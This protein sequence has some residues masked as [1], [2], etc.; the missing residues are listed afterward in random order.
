V[1]KPN[2][3]FLVVSY[4]VP[5][6]R[7]QYLQEETYKWRV[8]IHTVR[9]S[10]SLFPIDLI[11][12]Y[13][14]T[15]FSFFPYPITH[16][17]NRQ[18]SLPSPPSPPPPRTPRTPTPCTTSMSARRASMPLRL[19]LRPMG[20]RRALVRLGSM[21]GMGGRSPGRRWGARRRGRGRSWCVLDRNE[22][23][24]W[25]EGMHGVRLGV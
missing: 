16:T 22:L 5:D 24:L 1:L 6:N 21:K 14:S 15:S 20:R 7:L 25:S 17:Q 23:G 8:T 9:E 12:R 10:T 11:L 13:A 19:L 3:V 18:P 4:G 2:G